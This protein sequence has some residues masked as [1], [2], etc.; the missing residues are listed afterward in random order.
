MPNIGLDLVAISGCKI[1]LGRAILLVGSEDLPFGGVSTEDKVELEALDSVTIR[2]GAEAIV[3]VQWQAYPSRREP[4][5]LVEA[6]MGQPIM[7]FVVGLT[8]TLI[9]YSGSHNRSVSPRKD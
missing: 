5:G 9:N 8:C 2:P 7:G 1:Y 3:P 6:L 4:C